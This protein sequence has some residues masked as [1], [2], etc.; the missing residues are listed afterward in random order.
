MPVPI[1]TFLVF[2]RLWH[3][4]YSTQEVRP[5]LLTIMLF[6]LGYFGLGVSVFPWVV[7]FKFTIW[8]AAAAS[9]SQSLL[10]VGTLIFLPIILTYTAFSYYLFRGKVDDKSHY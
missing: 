6:L 8:D 10:L 4:L 2:L 7:P 5:F 3:D 9:T 1:I